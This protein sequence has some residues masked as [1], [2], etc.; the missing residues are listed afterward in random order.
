M[1]KAEEQSWPM[2]RRSRRREARRRMRKRGAAP[3]GGDAGVEDAEDE[4]EQG[5][6]SDSDSQKTASGNGEGLGKQESNTN[7]SADHEGGMGMG[8]GKALKKGLGGGVGKGKGSA[9]RGSGGKNKSNLVSGAGKR[10]ASGQP[11]TSRRKQ[12]PLRRMLDWLLGRRP[13]ART[14]ASP[15]GGKGSHGFTEGNDAFDRGRGPSST[16]QS[17]TN[18]RAGAGSTPTQDERSQRA[19]AQQRLVNEG[20][21]FSPAEGEA[22]NRNLGQKNGGEI[23]ANSAKRQ[24]FHFYPSPID[25]ETEG[26]NTNIGTKQ[27]DLEHIIPFIFFP[28]KA[29]AT[30]NTLERDHEDEGEGSTPASGNHSNPRSETSGA[31]SSAPPPASPIFGFFESIA[32]KLFEPKT[33]NSTPT[34]DTK[35]GLSRKHDDLSKNAID[36]NLNHPAGAGIGEEDAPVP[37]IEGSNRDKDAS[38]TASSVDKN[39]TDDKEVDEEVR[40]FGIKSLSGARRTRTKHAEGE[41]RDPWATSE[42]PIEEGNDADADAN[43]AHDVKADVANVNF[44]SACKDYGAV[45][46]HGSWRHRRARGTVN[47][48]FDYQHFTLKDDFKEVALELDRLDRLESQKLSR[49]FSKNSTS[50]NNTTSSTT[51]VPSDTDF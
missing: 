5:I 18:R 34:A 29:F 8:E 30:S 50:K 15:K 4:I 6:S 7:T 23:K 48:D 38:A 12:S 17:S 2:N 9:K 26:H 14:G 35:V 40:F 51:A 3:E 13:V 49:M 43:T 46:D 45:A 36:D 11:L 42:T 27:A 39:T 44:D 16:Q 47:C 37:D 32:Q 21:S 19:H 41:A 1:A 20:R 25:D 22:R 33:T 31:A 28:E 24:V 10:I